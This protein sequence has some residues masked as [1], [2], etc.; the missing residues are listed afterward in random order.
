MFS[1][2]GTWCPFHLIYLKPRIFLSSIQTVMEL[3][4]ILGLRHLVKRAPEM[5]VV[6]R[7]KGGTV[8]INIVTVF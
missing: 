5:C 6:T 8:C 3:I 1:E 4:K 2:M 7:L